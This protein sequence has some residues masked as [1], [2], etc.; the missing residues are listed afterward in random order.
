VTYILGTEKQSPAMKQFRTLR[1]KL[2]AQS[3][4]QQIA[5][6]ASTV[7]ATREFKV[8]TLSVPVV[9]VNGHWKA[10]GTQVE[11]LDR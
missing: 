4:G 10:N 7:T 5:N 2:S 9:S 3:S 8:G 11:L 6:W 1:K